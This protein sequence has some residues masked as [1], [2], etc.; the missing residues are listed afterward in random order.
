ALNNGINSLSRIAMGWT[1]DRFG[2]QNTLILTTVIC[3][4]LIASLWLSSASKAGGDKALWVAF[5]ATY[6]LAS[7]GYH[8]LFPTTVAE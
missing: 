1:G 3:A 8:A 6:G 5:V 7:A 2:R 4:V